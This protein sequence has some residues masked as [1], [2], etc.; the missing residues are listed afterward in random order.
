MRA[1]CALGVSVRRRRLFPEASAKLAIIVSL[2]ERS[3]EILQTRGRANPFSR[4]VEEVSQ[5]VKILPPV[6]EIIFDHWAEARPTRG[7][8]GMLRAHAARG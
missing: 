3:A 6:V 4:P 1:T 7:V 5:T 8:T 2:I